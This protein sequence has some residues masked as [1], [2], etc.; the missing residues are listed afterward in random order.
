MIII[1]IE[2]IISSLSQCEF[3]TGVMHIASFP[4]KSFTKLAF[5]QLI[6]TI[7]VDNLLGKKKVG[8]CP[9]SGLGSQRMWE[10]VPVR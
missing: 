2:R 3:N 5:P 9:V 10:R 6:T 8:C 7:V 4:V 1:M